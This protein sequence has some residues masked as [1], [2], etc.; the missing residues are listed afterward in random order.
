MVHVEPRDVLEALEKSR[1]D[2]PA[3][4]TPAEAE[5]IAHALSR[6]LAE[7]VSHHLPERLD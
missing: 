1:L 4:P 2:P 5:A 7:E 3:M 6:I